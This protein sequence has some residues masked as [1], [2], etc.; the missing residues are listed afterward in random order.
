MDSVCIPDLIICFPSLVTHSVEIRYILQTYPHVKQLLRLEHLAPPSLWVIYQIYRLKWVSCLLDHQ[1][2]LHSI[3][4]AINK[5]SKWY[6]SF[7]TPTSNPSLFLD[8]EEEW[9]A[10]WTELASVCPLTSGGGGEQGAMRE[11]MLG[12]GAKEA[13]FIGSPPG[14]NLLVEVHQESWINGHNAYWI[15][16][17][18][19]IGGKSDN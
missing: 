11:D 3:S 2:A 1:A 18:H 14:A 17:F 6:V 19:L 8:I 10:T 15:E 13:S 5:S 7:S 9:N 12:T 16:I 4:G